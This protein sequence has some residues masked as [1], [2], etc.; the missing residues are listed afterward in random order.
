[1]R[2]DPRS[3][4]VG[5][6]C[7]LALLALALVGSAQQLHALMHANSDLSAPLVMGDVAHRYVHAQLVTGRVGWW[8]GLWVVQLLRPVPGGL[9]LADWL[10]IVATA[11]LAGLVA[12]QARRV[13]SDVSALIVALVALA[14]GVGA[15]SYDA[16]W[17]A[18]A[19]TWWAMALMG[20]AAVRLA[21]TTRRP[22]TGTIVL[23][24]GAVVAVAVTA[25]GDQLAL[26]GGA[27]PL[28][29]AAVAIARWR[30]WWLAA[31]FLAAAGA[32]WALSVGVAAL[33]RS[34]G[35][36]RQDYPV[37][38]V[39][40][41]QLGKAFDGL[42]EASRQVWASPLTAGRLAG[43]VGAVLAGAAVLAGLAVLVR[44]MMRGGTPQG[45]QRS[46]WAAFWLPALLGYLLA[47][48]LTTAGALIGPSVVR[49]LYGVPLAA[50]ATL[51]PL[52]ALRHV[53]WPAALGAAALACLTA[54]ALLVKPIQPP[55]LAA[56]LSRS[57][58]FPQIEQVAAREH[59]TRGFAS[60]WAAYP[61]VLHSGRR[62]DVT[63][64][65]TCTL[66]GQIEL[67]AMYIHYI[68]Q[69]YAPRPGIRSFLLVDLSGLAG[70]GFSPAWVQRL[71]A[72]LQPV[73]VVP[74]ADGMEMAI[75]DHDVAADIHPNG[76][77]GDPRLGHGGPLAP[78]A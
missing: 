71:P 41:H 76:G 32:T 46:V 17:S 68:D 62:L 74:I 51:G 39:K 37:D 42:V 56:D 49:Y 4:A 61:L 38:L 64:A 27:A 59:V 14:G 69:A 21:G 31:V 55:P 66:N 45:L 75:F 18:R 26:V 70:A 43:D 52:G 16:S 65:G 48:W 7:V 23:G 58:L 24:A 8:G 29:V 44:T 1:M 54:A 34:A 40:W 30:R 13:W 20:L 67:C 2:L 19:P 73:R 6:V 28:V 53:R 77:L 15:W 10:P 33:A 35:Y 12:W 22:S 72:D 9:W 3:G 78:T 47:F 50:A 25:S 63:P 57:A 11:A 60:Y 36:L 5:L